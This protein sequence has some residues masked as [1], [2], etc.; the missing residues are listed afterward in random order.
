VDSTSTG[1]FG[2]TDI[3]LGVQYRFELQKPQWVPFVGGGLD[4]LLTDFTFPNGVN[5]SVDD[6]VGFYVK[7]GIDYF[8]MR[9][10]AVTAEVKAV[11][12]IQADFRGQ[13]RPPGH[14]D[15]SNFSSTF[16]IRYFFY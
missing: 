15:P 9:Q 3:G 8:I 14:F 2:I 4:I 16:G 10:F 1:D 12:A 6:T 7:G 5:A 13:G 11:T